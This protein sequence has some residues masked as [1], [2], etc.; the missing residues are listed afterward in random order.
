M[1]CVWVT[2]CV[3]LSH[4]HTESHSLA[5]RPITWIEA[6]SYILLYGIRTRVLVSLAIL[7][8]VAANAEKPRYGSNSRRYGKAFIGVCVRSITHSSH[9]NIGCY[10]IRFPLHTHS[11][12]NAYTPAPCHLWIFVKTSAKN[13]SHRTASNANR[14]SVYVFFLF[15]SFFHF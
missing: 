1:L 3:V 2:L 15:A 12:R 10:T 6:V 9:T 8:A 14:L 13:M 11:Q 5:R 4:T 7:V